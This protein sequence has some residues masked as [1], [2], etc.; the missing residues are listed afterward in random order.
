[1]P[2]QIE[3][4]RIFLSLYI[5]SVI[6]I[7]LVLIFILEQ[8][9]GWD[10]HIGGILPRSY[11]GLWGLIFHGF[12]HDDW[13]HL[14]NNVLSL[15]VLSTFVCYFYTPL[16]G[17]IIL[18]SY[19]ITGILLWI[20]GRPNWHIGASGLIYAL[21]FFLFWSGLFR[22]YIPLI[23]ISLIVVLLYGNSV[24][25]IFPWEQTKN[26]SWEG[27]LTGGIAGTIL[28]IIYRKKGPQ[29]PIYEDDSDE[30]DKLLEYDYQNEEI[31]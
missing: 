10:F 26:M 16:E 28:A 6:C 20:I 22:R 5:P 4:K 23:A 7:I 9:M 31:I 24:W 27:H 14:L 17:K 18:Y 25:Y 11:K 1:M 19:L 3:K 21:S 13:Q 8:G 30:D 15:F 2:A 12:I 29:K